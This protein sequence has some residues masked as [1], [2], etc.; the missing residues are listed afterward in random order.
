MDAN[1]TIH[2]YVFRINEAVGH[3]F[4]TD[5]PGLEPGAD[6]EKEK[7]IEFYRLP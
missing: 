7:T 4:G 5:T 1:Q 6:G 2:H 3:P